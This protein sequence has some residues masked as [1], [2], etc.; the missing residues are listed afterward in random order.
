MRGDSAPCLPL[1]GEYVFVTYLKRG[2]HQ[3]GAAERSASQSD[4]ASRE[5]C[6]VRVPQGVWFRKL[7][8]GLKGSV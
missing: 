1:P 7:G 3:A 6:A 4:G 2:K 5:R 8:W